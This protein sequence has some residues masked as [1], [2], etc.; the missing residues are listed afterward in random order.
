[1]KQ[2]W[3]SEK[4][5][6]WFKLT[7]VKLYKSRIVPLTGKAEWKYIGMWNEQDGMLKVECGTSPLPELSDYR[8]EPL[9]GIE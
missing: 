9:V 8:N 6:C 2:I 5:H 7:G 1:M 4:F 3:Y